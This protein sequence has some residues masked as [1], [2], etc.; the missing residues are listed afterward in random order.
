VAAERAEHREALGDRVS[1]VDAARI[2][3]RRLVR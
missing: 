1:T 3:A 2:V